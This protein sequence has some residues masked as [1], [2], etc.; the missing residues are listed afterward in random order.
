MLWHYRCPGCSQDL[1][2][3]W[4]W[5]RN[6]VHCPQCQLSH[7]PPTPSEDHT[8]FVGTDTWPKD[9]E[10]TVIRLK[11]T[12]CAVPTCYNDYGTLAHRIPV[13]R[14]GRT[15]IENLVPLCEHHARLM[16]DRPYAEWLTELQ[17]EASQPEPFEIT[18]T[19]KDRPEDE[20]AVAGF[21]LVNYIQP[22]A[23]RLDEP[24]LPNGCR[25]VAAVPF[26]PGPAKRLQFD[27]H[28]LRETEGA[29]RVVL[30]TWANSNPPDLRSFPKG[31]NC[32]SI[33]NQHQGT[34]GQTG[35][36]TLQ[37][38]LPSPAEGRWVAAVI[39]VEEGGK[40]ALDEYLLNAVG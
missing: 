15:S 12:T 29:C 25:F 28:W 16:G 31:L 3:D 39:V 20:G 13:S 2:V 37:L 24:E 34:A 26:L 21:R 11:G 5:L 33:G 17:E 22:L 19:R 18:I 27:Y 32:A 35:E 1:E 7:Y 10:D 6:E 38:S 4:E 8:A 23:A 14:E 9:L 40:L 36:G 30:L